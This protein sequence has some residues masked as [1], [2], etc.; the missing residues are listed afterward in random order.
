MKLFLLLC[1]CLMSQGAWAQDDNALA[2]SF[3][4]PVEEVQA[5][6]QKGIP[7][8]EVGQVLLQAARAGVVPDVIVALRQTGW[9]WD[10]IRLAVGNPGG[11]TKMVAAAAAAQMPSYGYAAYGYGDFLGMGYGMGGYS[12]IAG[13]GMPSL[14]MGCCWSGYFQNPLF[15]LTCQ[16]LSV[17]I[18]P[19]RFF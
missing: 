7:D 15:G 5:I 17:D 9:S 1:S 12:G 16:N 14:G 11:L 4:V 8:A 6:A 13:L 19:G 3:K 2:Q 10:S 18:R